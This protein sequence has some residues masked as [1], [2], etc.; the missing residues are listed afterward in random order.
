M[1]AQ[2]NTIQEY[3]RT[4]SGLAKLEHRHDG[5]FAFEPKRAP[6]PE[7][8]APRALLPDLGE[9]WTGLIDQPRH[10]HTVLE[11]RRR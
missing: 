3:T 4:V 10:R 11:L 1:L 8:F 2:E 9:Q 6:V 7:R 5:H